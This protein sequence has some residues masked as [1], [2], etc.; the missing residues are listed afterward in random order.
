MGGRGKWCHSDL[1]RGRGGTQEE[2]IFL[3]SCVCLLMKTSADDYFSGC[4]KTIFASL[5]IQ[6]KTQKPKK[7]TA[8]NT[9]TSVVD[10]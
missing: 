1:L 3:N 10:H 7:L 9:C 2:Y 6:K 4:L 8:T 5:K